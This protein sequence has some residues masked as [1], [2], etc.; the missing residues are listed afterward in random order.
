MF[1]V[2]IG[3]IVLLLLARILGDIFQRLGMPKLLGNIL[4]GVLVGPLSL[5]VPAEISLFAYIGAVLIIFQFGLRNIPKEE[6]F[7]HR[8]QILPFSAILFLLPFTLIFIFLLYSGVPAGVSFLL[9]TA[10]SIPSLKLRKKMTEGTAVLSALIGLS[11]VSLFFLLQNISDLS[12]VITFTSSFVLLLGSFLVAERIVPIFIR[13]SRSIHTSEAQLISALILIVTLGAIAGYVGINGYTGAFLAG[14]ILSGLPKAQVGF[15]DKVR[16]LSDN[17]FAP[18]F[19][20][21]AGMLFDLGSLSV[22]SLYFAGFALVTKV[23][24]GLLWAYKT[25]TSPKPSIQGAELVI[26]SGIFGFIF[27]LPSLI[28]SLFASFILLVFALG[29]VA[30]E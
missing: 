22:F 9:S 2:F 11:L 16:T 13:V 21:W 20:G 24:S 15:T 19:F 1:Y 5:F 4:A 23:V 27:F 7:K 10:I 18:I 8:K 29:V 30:R 28:N 6:V 14:I 26:A 12:Q 25:K 17:V 3:L